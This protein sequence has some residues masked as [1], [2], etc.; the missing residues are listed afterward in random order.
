MYESDTIEFSGTDDLDAVTD[1]ITEA[2]GSQVRHALKTNGQDDD[3]H[4]YSIV[5]DYEIRDGWVQ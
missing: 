2:I 1:R 5:V 4:L 3:A